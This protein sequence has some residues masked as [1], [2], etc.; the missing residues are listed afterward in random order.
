MKRTERHH[1]KENE[2]DRLARQARETVGTWKRETTVAIAAVVIVGAGVLGYVAWKDRINSRAEAMLAEALA[3]TEVRVGAPV[4]PG[5]PGAGPSFATERARS[6]AALVKFK[7]AADAY[8]DADAG[9]FA[10]YRQAG[11]E[12][13]LGN[14][15]QAAPTYQ[16]V[17]DRAGDRIYGQM[18]RLGLAEAQARSGQYDQAINT[19]KELA[20]RKD[21]PLPVDGILMQL[22]LAY[23]DAGKK[24]DAQQTFNRLVEEYPDSPFGMDAKKELESLKKT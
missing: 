4:A 6:E 16:Q 9:I 24:A 17:I 20:Q 22:G 8:P 21:G 13:E 14:T 7:A 5:T 3:V 11:V 10:R 12:M 19:F 23:R 2:L 15:Q 18:A 1:L